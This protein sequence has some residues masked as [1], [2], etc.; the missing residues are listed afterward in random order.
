M[1]QVQSVLLGI[2]SPPTHASAYWKP[3]HPFSIDR[4]SDNAHN[5]RLPLWGHV[6]KKKSPRQGRIW[7]KSSHE[8]K[9]PLTSGL[10][11]EQSIS[12]ASFSLVQNKISNKYYESKWIYLFIYKL[13]KLFFYS[14]YLLVNFSIVGWNKKY[15][16]IYFLFAIAIVL[17]G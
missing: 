7:E 3:H 1:T 11:V 5:Q 4:A 14:H 13:N 9:R 10:Q 2:T 6:T 17:I 16:F 8:F 12:C 15:L